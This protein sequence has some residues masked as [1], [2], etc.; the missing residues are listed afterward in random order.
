[1]KLVLHASKAFIVKKRW[2]FMPTRELVLHASKAFICEGLT[3]CLSDRE[4]GSFFDGQQKLVLHAVKA[5]IVKTEAGFF[6]ACSRQKL[7]FM[8]VQAFIVQ[9]DWCVS[10]DSKLV[11][12]C[13]TDS[14]FLHASK[15]FYI[16][17]GRRLVVSLRQKLVLHASKAFIVKKLVLHASKSRSL[18]TE[19]CAMKYR[20]FISKSEEWMR[21]VHH[22]RKQLLSLSGQLISI[23][24][25]VT[26]LLERTIKLQ[27]QLPQKVLPLVSSGMKPQ[28][29]LSQ[30]TLVEMTL[31]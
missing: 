23:E 4:L 20:L 24:K 1:Q 14:W 15:A 9:L 3:V 5:F 25:E 6:M 30:N 27:E 8:P 12:S 13:Q 18:F 21:K 2:F 31:G 22:V 11:L 26:M 7:Y 29:Y 16:V 10:Q 17:E 19:E 28:A